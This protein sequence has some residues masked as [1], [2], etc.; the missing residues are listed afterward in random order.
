MQ[1]IFARIDALR[2][3]EQWLNAP[4]PIDSTEDGMII[5]FSEKHL[6]KDQFPID[7]T[8]EGIAISSRDEHP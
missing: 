8:E 3:E 5:F 7:F 1:S 4:Y 2:N 6:L